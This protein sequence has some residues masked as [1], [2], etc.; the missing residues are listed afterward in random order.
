MRR[1]MKIER[2]CLIITL[3]KL[4]ELYEIVDDIDANDG[5]IVFNVGILW[6]W[7]INLKQIIN[8]VGGLNR[9]YSCVGRVTVMSIYK[10]A[11][12]AYTC[13]EVDFITSS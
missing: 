7:I 2:V 4:N 8:I 1:D 12:C 3:I 13:L 10:G 5:N 6:T 9:Q 11:Q